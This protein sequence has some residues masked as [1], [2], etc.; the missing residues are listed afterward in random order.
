M[1]RITRGAWVGT[2][3]LAGAAAACASAGPTGYDDPADASGP[4]H[5]D[6]A[7]AD[8][9]AGDRGSS[10]PAEAG[11]DGADATFDAT[12]PT[13]VEASTAVEAGEAASP[14]EAGSQP[15]AGVDAKEE[16]AAE[17]STV[18]EAGADA[19]AGIVATAGPEAGPEPT[20]EAGPEPAPEAG[21]DATADAPTEGASTLEAG[22]DAATDAGPE[23][24]TIV[25]PVCDGVIGAGEYG[26]AAN[27]GS[28][29]TGQTWY[30]TWDD[31]NLYVALQNANIGE[32]LVLYLAIA[33]GTDAGPGGGTTVG[34]VYDG[35][36]ATTLP[37][38]A[39]LV[40]YAR[41]G[42]TQARTSSGGAWGAPD[43]TAVVQCDNGTTQVREEVVPWSLLG[44]RP[45]SFGWLAYVAAPQ[46]QN[47]QGYIYGQVPAGNPGG[48]PANND[49]FT[50][51][52]EVTDATPGVGTPFADVQ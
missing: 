20:I 46:P 40:F 2:V 26:G 1:R 19:D 37:F 9:A 7:P 13:P 35:T 28:S 38:P 16:A 21:P 47:P 36:D 34:Q 39:D 18:A 41:D 52:F 4:P 17:A 51:Y 45:S 10:A 22:V 5:Y 33:P 11:A 50:Q 6:S 15:E 32:G 12:G 44:G 48:A 29:A 49:T 3:L 25:P 14:G 27:Q 31:T 43:Q 30:M 24:A 8:D 42:Y 23:A